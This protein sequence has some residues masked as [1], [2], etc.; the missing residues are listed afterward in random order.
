MLLSQVYG[1]NLMHLKA[2]HSH[3]WAIKP[4]LFISPKRRRGLSYQKE[5][6]LKLIHLL[7]NT[8]DSIKATNPVN[9]T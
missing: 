1:P 2:P 8:S 9:G 7:Y 4:I 6:T 5:T 3:K